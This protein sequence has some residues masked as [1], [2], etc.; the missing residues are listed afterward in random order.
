MR[1]L[2]EIWRSR[3]TLAVVYFAFGVVCTIVFTEIATDYK[4]DLDIKFAVN[5]NGS[6]TA[7]ALPPYNNF[8]T[9]VVVPE[10]S[11][12]PEIARALRGE[13]N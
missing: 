1:T 2:K 8:D 4:F 12:V 10:E 11:E 13:A 5:R 3:Y 7:T 9:A 6:G